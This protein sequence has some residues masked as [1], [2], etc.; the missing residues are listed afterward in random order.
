M[1]WHAY[2]SFVCDIDYNKYATNIREKTVNAINVK[3][4][5]VVRWRSNVKIML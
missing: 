1:A 2:P 3:R 5:N 4:P